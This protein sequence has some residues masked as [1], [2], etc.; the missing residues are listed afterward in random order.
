MSKTRAEIEAEIARLTARLDHVGFDPAF[1]PAELVRWDPSLLGAVL[2]IKHYEDIPE[3][4]FDTLYVNSGYNVGGLLHSFE[5]D[6]CY[7]RS[8]SNCTFN[9]DGTWPSHLP[10]GCME[11][12]GVLG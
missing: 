12:I 7:G 6:Q 5:L 8:R 11:T 10:S 1:T 3:I 9:F 2:H 4:A